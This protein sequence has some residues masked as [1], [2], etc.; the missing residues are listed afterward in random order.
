MAKFRLYVREETAVVKT[1]VFEADTVDDAE[2]AAENED[3]RDPSWI[4]IG[5]DTSADV[6]HD[7]TEVEAHGHDANGLPIVWQN[8]N[9]EE[10]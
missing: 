4:E 2:E 3:W 8:V 9:D 7:L 6:L 5:R 1:K 10:V